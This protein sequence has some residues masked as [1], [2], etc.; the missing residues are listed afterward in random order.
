MSMLATIANAAPRALAQQGASSKWGMLAVAVGV[1]IGVALLVTI[2]AMRAGAARRRGALARGG[3]A[4]AAVGEIEPIP[5]ATKALRSRYADLPGLS[6]M[7]GTVK[8]AYRADLDGRELTIFHHNLTTMAGS[9]PVV[10]D[11]TVYACEAPDWPTVKIAPRR[12]FSRVALKFG[13]AGGL[14]LENDAFNRAFWV[15]TDDEPFAVTLLSPEMQAFLLERPDLRWRIRNG[16]VVLIYRGPLRSK[17]L[18]ASIDRL[19]RFW[20]LVPPELDAWAARYGDAPQ[21]A[22]R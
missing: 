11:H 8:S 1:A 21:G 3:A 9:T 16:E 5:D 7:R 10:I 17:R 6:R 2:I 22:P 19:R 15:G 12:F 20:S 13:K 18:G 4:E 14:M